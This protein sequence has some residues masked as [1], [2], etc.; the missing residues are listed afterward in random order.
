[1]V[2]SIHNQ[3]HFHNSICLLSL[4]GTKKEKKKKAIITAALRMNEVDPASNF[5]LALLRP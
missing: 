5:W 3:Y 1:M 2:A 4:E